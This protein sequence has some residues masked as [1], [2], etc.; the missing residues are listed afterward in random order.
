MKA[1]AGILVRFMHWLDSLVQGSLASQLHP[2]IVHLCAHMTL[3]E[4]LKTHL[5]LS[6][7]YALPL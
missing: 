1:L 6:E 4:I 3:G 5:L 7:G 2:I